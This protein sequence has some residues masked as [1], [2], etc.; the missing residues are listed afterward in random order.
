MSG[1]GVEPRA[2]LALQIADEFDDGI[3]RSA[4]IL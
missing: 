3:R 4:R 2:A 1:A